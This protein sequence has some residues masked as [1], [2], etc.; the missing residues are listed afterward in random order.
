MTMG[1]DVF[2]QQFGHVHALHVGEQQ[3]DVIHPFRLDAQGFFHVTSL[4]ESR[5]CVQI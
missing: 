5:Y 4:S 1:R 3:R 2:I